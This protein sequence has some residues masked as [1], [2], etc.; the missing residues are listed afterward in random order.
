M[1]PTNSAATQYNPEDPPSDPALLQAYLRQEFAKLKAALDI[2]ADGFDPVV[3]VAPPK[4][5]EG[6]RR[7]ADGVS[8]NPGAGKGVYSYQSGVWVKL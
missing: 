8:W 6:M 5:R 4:P 3:Y 7:L 2:L 1:R